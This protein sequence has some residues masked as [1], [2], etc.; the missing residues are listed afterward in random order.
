[1]YGTVGE[2]KCTGN[3]YDTETIFIIVSGMIE[4]RIQTEGEEKREKM[5]S[6]FSVGQHFSET[7]IGLLESE[8]KNA[9]AVCLVKTECLILQKHEYNEIQKSIN[10]LDNH[11][12]MPAAGTKDYVLAV[13]SKA[14]NK[15]S[16]T[17]IHYKLTSSFCINVTSCRRDI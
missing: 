7:D 4:L 10:K 13:L 5:I 17:G 2:S 8:Y 14:R 16:T 9:T 1:M 11:G 15:R 6:T 3:S 12:V